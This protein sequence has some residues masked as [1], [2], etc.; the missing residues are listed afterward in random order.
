VKATELAVKTYLT[1][2]IT[3]AEMV[4]RSTDPLVQ[5]FM[6][7][8][9]DLFPEFISTDY[10]N[11]F[12][13]GGMGSQWAL[14]VNQTTVMYFENVASSQ[15]YVERQFDIIRGWA[16]EQDQR[17]GITAPVRQPHAFIVMPFE[18]PWSNDSFGFIMRAV[19]AQGG[20][21]DATRADQIDR[22]GRITDQ[23]IEELRTCDVIIA[24]ITGN[25]PNVAWELGYAYA[26]GKPCAITMSRGNAAPFDIYDHRRVDYS[27]PPT[28]EEEERLTAILRN[29]IGR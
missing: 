24:D 19:E 28:A 9:V 11:A 5:R 13:G 16:K 1:P 4:V 22:T 25:N 27:N 12:A 8:T 10:P 21:L 7:P 20:A 2:R 23:I 14:N 18:E 29:A 3:P 6:P 17:S 26:Q 15:Q